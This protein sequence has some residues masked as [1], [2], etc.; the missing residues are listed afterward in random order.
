MGTAA[1]PANPNAQATNTPTNK[2]L[3][4]TGGSVVGSAISTIVI[5]LIE[6]KWGKLPEPVSGAIGILITAVVTFVA[7][8]FTPHGANEAIIKNAAGQ[9]VSARV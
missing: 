8:Y 1:V 3:A 5:Y 4:A 7:G 2:T 9:L 6:R